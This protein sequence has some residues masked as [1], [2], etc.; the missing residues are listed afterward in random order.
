MFL[1][2]GFWHLFLNMLA[3]WMFGVE[4]EYTW[5]SRR[6]LIYYLL[7]GLGAGIVNLL[8]AP[9]LGQAA[10]TVGASGAIFGVLIAFGMLFP[11]RPIYLYLLLPVRAKY[12]VLG[13]I[14]LELFYGVT[15]RPTAWPTSRIWAARRSA[16]LFTSRRPRYHP[17]PPLVLDSCAGVRICDA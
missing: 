6:F 13:Y 3:L 8:V 12:F 4:L 5:G 10:P 2:G 9:L 15:G 11:D 17:A 1:H 7:C 14:A 16:S